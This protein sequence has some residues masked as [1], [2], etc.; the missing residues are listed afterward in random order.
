MPTDMQALHLSLRILLDD[1]KKLFRKR[2]TVQ[3]SDHLNSSTCRWNC[4][5]LK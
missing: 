2:E 5:E 4:L 3:L 1:V